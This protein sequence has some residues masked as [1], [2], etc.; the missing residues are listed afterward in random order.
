MHSGNVFFNP[1]LLDLMNLLV[2]YG[3]P[4]SGCC[5]CT[6]TALCNFKDGQKKILKS[7]RSRIVCFVA[8]LFNTAPKGHLHSPTTLVKFQYFFNIVHAFIVCMIYRL[9]YMLFNLRIVQILRTQVRKFFFYEPRFVK[10]EPR[11]VFFTILW[12][13]HH[14]DF[15]W[16][17][18]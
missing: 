15:V 7:N 18:I 14:C 4:S 8:L 3:T 13:I 5:Y 9:T 10:Y 1:C 16:L 12:N 11:F 2:P 17:T 6:V